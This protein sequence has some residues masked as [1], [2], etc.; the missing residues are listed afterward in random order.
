MLSIF[1]DLFSYGLLTPVLIRLGLF[2]ALFYFGWMTIFRKRVLF[3]KK[4]EE[5]KYPLADFMPWPFGV[6]SLVSAGFILIGF[7]VQGVA[8]VA[9]YLFL[10]FYLVD[11]GEKKIFSVP[12]IF[13]LVL[14]LFAVSLLFSGAGFWAID[15]PL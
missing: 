6:L 5:S 2:V 8:I 12:G 3:A 14:V 9:I 13:Y 15:L 10:N 11:S 4:L 7:L 1:P